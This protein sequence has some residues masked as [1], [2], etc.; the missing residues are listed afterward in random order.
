MNIRTNI[1]H[2]RISSYLLILFESRAGTE[3]E[4][5]CSRSQ[6]SEPGR[7][8]WFILQRPPRMA[9]FFL[10]F[11][12]ELNNNAVNGVF[13]RSVAPVPLTSFGG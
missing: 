8:N 1:V 12:S 2:I 4:Q 11:Y 7:V 13:R 10:L 3:F 6:N 9:V 5:G